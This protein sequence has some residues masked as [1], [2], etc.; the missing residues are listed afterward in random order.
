MEILDQFFTHEYLRYSAEC[1]RLGR[2]ARRPQIEASRSKIEAARSKVWIERLGEF[3]R[4]MLT[5][6]SGHHHVFVP[7]PVR[8]RR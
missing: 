6:A 3:R 2:L 4:H 7:R 5:F 8:V 1:R